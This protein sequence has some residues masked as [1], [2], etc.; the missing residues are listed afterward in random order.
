MQLHS[1]MTITA[2]NRY[3]TRNNLVFKPEIMIR[4]GD[5]TLYINDSFDL[6]AALGGVFKRNHPNEYKKGVINLYLD[7]LFK[8][9]LEI[10]KHNTLDA[11]PEA[12]HLLEW[13]SFLDDELRD[14]LMTIEL[15]LDF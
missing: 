9:C 5:E 2:T 10:Q 15:N 4:I 7:P 6:S 11:A 1:T 13:L 3:R 12:E 14:E 8:A